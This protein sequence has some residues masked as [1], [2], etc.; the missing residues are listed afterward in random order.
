MD[1]DFERITEV[2]HQPLERLL[3]DDPFHT[4]AGEDLSDSERRYASKALAA[5]TLRGYRS[6]WAEFTAWCTGHGLA[7]LPAD[8]A[9]VSSHIAFL[10]DS[11]ARTG[12]I[13]RRLSAIR[14]AHLAQSQPDPTSHGRVRRVWAGV[15]RSNTEDPDQ[16]R[17]LMPPELFAVVGAIPVEIVDGSGRQAPRLIGLRN[18]ALLLV[19]FYGALRRSEI[20]DLDVESLTPDP[21]GLLANLGRTKTNQEGEHV[22]AVALRRPARSRRL[23]QPAVVL[24]DPQAVGKRRVGSTGPDKLPKDDAVVVCVSLLQHRPVEERRTL[25]EP[26]KRTSCC[27]E[28]GRSGVRAHVPGEDLHRLP[29]EACD[30][31][32]SDE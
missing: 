6:D 22:A 25:A 23:Q 31:V 19:G 1:K 14:A 29:R 30:D 18:R 9:T 3:V 4:V 10:A 28:A 24:N 11:Q 16:A 27:R 2:T 20:S 17:P 21:R 12:T 13:A 7:A 32:L 5:N 15:K 8:P 26:R